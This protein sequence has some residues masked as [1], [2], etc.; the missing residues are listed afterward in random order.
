MIPMDRMVFPEPPRVAEI[1]ILGKAI[2]FDRVKNDR[3]SQKHRQKPNCSAQ[4]V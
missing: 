3:L 2:P 1:M 4:G